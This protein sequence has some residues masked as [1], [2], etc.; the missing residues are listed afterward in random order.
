MVGKAAGRLMRTPKFRGKARVARVLLRSVN[1]G[2]V[3]SS[4]GPM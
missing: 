4:Y 1:G 2:A 3:R